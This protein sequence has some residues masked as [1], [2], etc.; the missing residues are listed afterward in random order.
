M[1][2]IAGFLQPKTAALID[3]RQTVERMAS[4]LRHRGPDHQGVWL[5]DA[6]ILALGHRRLSIIDLSAAGHQPMASTSGR[7]VIAFNGE[8]Y[9]HTDLRGIL[10]AEQGVEWRGSSDT[11]TLLAAI[12]RWGVKT[13]LER[14]VGMFAIVLWDMRT[15]TLTLA[16]DRM[17]EKPLYYGRSRGVFLFASEL[18]AFRAFPGF[19]AELDP[20]SLGLYFAFNYVPAPRSVFKHIY[21]LMPGTMLT[22]NE[23]GTETCDTFWSLDEVFRQPHFAGSPEDAVDEVERL[24]KEAIRMQSVADV[25]LGAFLSGGIDSSTIVALMQDAASRPVH[26]FSIGFDEENFNEARYAA[27]VAHYLGTNHTEMVVTSADAIALVSHLPEIWDEPFADSSQLPTAIVAKLARQKVTVSLSG[28]GGDELFCGYDHYFR[29]KMIEELRT[30][31]LLRFLLR[32]VPLTWIAGGFKAVPHRMARDVT[33]RRLQNLAHLLESRTPRDR[34]I[35]HIMSWKKAADLISN[36]NISAY[37]LTDFAPPVDTEYFNLISGIDAKTYLPDD[38]LVKVDRAAMAASLETRVPLLDHRLVELAFA[39]PFSYKFREG[40]T[41]WPLRKI[42]YKHVPRSLVDRPKRG[43]S[44]PIA[45]WLRGPLREWADD[46]LSPASLAKDGVLVPDPI[47]RTWQQHRS[48]T[49]NWEN[50]LW[51]VLMF[52]AWRAHYV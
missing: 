50:R 49:H 51:I 22:L 5:D 14:S 46:L 42:L 29:S 32:T 9:N 40:Q 24:L 52:Q 41:K 8:I 13:A 17:G 45:D 4:A 23:N 19:E 10:D 18:K 3:P 6:G 38:I 34:Y 26:T 39:L 27:E 37:P 35:A 15:R 1:C 16:R 25:P 7:F 33:V 2:G 47:I 12:E 11:E 20:D 21:K 28:D 48:G 36:T 44:V 43:F 31:W 30:K